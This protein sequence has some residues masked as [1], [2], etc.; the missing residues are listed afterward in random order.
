MHLKVFLHYSGNFPANGSGMCSEDSQGQYSSKESISL[1]QK[2]T[3][4][5]A[6]TGHNGIEGELV[7][8]EVNIWEWGNCLQFEDFQTIA[9]HLLIFQLQKWIYAA[10]K[11][12][13]DVRVKW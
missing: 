2:T 6:S 13:Q 8:W 11:K 4:V 10:E 5:Q 9:F 12:T 7:A 3:W 1:C